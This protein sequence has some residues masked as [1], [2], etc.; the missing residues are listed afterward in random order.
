MVHSKLEKNRKR[1]AN[2]AK[3]MTQ[4][5]VLT[6]HVMITIPIGAMGTHED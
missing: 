4:L 5:E 3:V 6:Q 2:M 1:D